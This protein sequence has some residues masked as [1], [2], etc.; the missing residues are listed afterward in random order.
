MICCYQFLIM[1]NERRLTKTEAQNIR[2]SVE[3]MYKIQQFTGTEILGFVHANCVSLNKT[4]IFIPVLELKKYTYTY[5]KIF[6][7]SA[8]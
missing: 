1:E 6:V 5:V 8:D 7:F 2:S 4:H 3:L